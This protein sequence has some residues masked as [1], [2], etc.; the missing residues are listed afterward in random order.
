MSRRERIIETLSSTEEPL[1]VNQIA[2]QLGLNPR[3]AKSI[4][5]DLEHVARSL[6]TSDKALLMVPPTCKTCGY[7][8]RDLDKPRRPSK[9]P[10]CKSERISSPLFIIRPKDG[11]RHG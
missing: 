5:E 3:E 9:C 10:R 6:R 11:S 1:D 2:A 7:V 4:Y 8:F